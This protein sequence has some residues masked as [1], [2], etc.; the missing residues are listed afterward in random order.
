MVNR[1]FSIKTGIF[2]FTGLI[3]FLFV[4]FSIL[5]YNNYYYTRKILSKDQLINK[6][7]L[8]PGQIELMHQRFL[9]IDALNDNFYLTEKS[10]SLDSIAVLTTNIK[11]VYDS[12]LNKSDIPVSSETKHRIEILISQYDL[13]NNK[14]ASL[15][16]QILERGY[17]S[18][19]KAG[20]WVRFAKYSQELAVIY[21]NSALVKKISELNSQI[22]DYQLNKNPEKLNQLLEDINSLKITLNLQSNSLCVGVSEVNR[23]RL[24]RELDNLASLT[25]SIQKK[26]LRVGFSLGDGLISDTHNLLLNITDKSNDIYQNI[27]TDISNRIFLS[28][29]LKFALIIIFGLLFYLVFYQFVSEITRSLNKI[30]IFADELNLGKLP[31][32][33]NVG[34]STEMQELSSVFQSY[35]ENIRK[36]IKFASQL[37][38]G[39]SEEKL[40]PTSDEDTLAIALLDMEESLL[41]ASEEDRKYKEDEQKR[42]WANEGLAQFSDILRV[43]TDNIVS[44][45]DELISNLVKYL[46]ANM[47]EIYVY[48][49]NDAYNVH[50]ELVSAFAWDRK[51]Y[52]TKRIELGDGLV[53][54]CA[55]EK[56]RIFITEIPENYVEITS[57]LGDSKPKCLLI[58]PLKTEN[59]IFGIVELASFEIFKPFEIEFVEKLAQSIASTFSA[60]KIN[61][62]TS[63]LL[64]QSKKQQ[65]NMS[66]QE[67]E[68]RQN[69][70]ELQATQEEAARR[71][72]EINS[73][74]KAVDASALVLQTDL[75]GRVIEVNRKFATA[76]KLH[77]DEIIGKT[78]RS[79]FVFKT[80]SEEFYRLLQDLKS[81]KIITRSEEHTTADNTVIYLEIH[82]SPIL[83]SDGNPYKVLGIATNVSAY[84][85]LEKTLTKKDEVL[86]NVDLNYNQLKDIVQNGFVVCELLP[87]GT[88]IDVNKNYIELTGYHKTEVL[89]Q[90][91][92][93]F[94]DAEEL[95]QFDMI[96]TEV[97]KDKPYQ[98]VMKRTKPTGDSFWM[99]T[100]LIPNRDKNG[101]I[102]KVYLMAQDVTE[103]KLKYQVLEEANKEIDR[104]RENLT[105]EK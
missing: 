82:Y 20:E 101:N 103:K 22:T 11:A 72:A 59:Q 2:Y 99:M 1:N 14:Y 75:E 4:L 76:L 16:R 21:G 30:K 68:M 39:Q 8:I 92:R 77:R 50:L 65:E 52:L 31:K 42:A 94:L 3:V 28:F 98:G 36:K 10:S 93:K 100:S 49:D 53:G 85:E 37:K 24:I 67:E 91:Y 38:L 81:G 29:L 43:Q 96:W 56:Q 44:L 41:K 48:N 70:E 74:V 26:D 23:L 34:E 95:K 87:N 69:L 12:I 55:L 13:L 9:Q 80:E 15:K 17:Y 105:S 40:V 60:V 61:I 63:L 18:T 25:I 32:T 19:G 97:L 79:I 58:I 88:I 83:D 57:G 7:Q 62:N 6:T 104:L 51:K 86:K 73:L 64:E 89:N 27:Q 84:R 45:S 46:K 90:D 66:Q 78:L 33:P 71:E 5:Q 102:N 54:T 35:V 47:G